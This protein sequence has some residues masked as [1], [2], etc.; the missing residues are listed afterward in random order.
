MGELGGEILTPGSD[1]TLGG[2]ALQ[3]PLPVAGMITSPQGY[4]TD[5]ITGETSYHMSACRLGT[6]KSGVPMNTIRIIPR[7]HPALPPGRYT[8]QPSR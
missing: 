8:P 4:R 1:T 7:H 2:G 6:A 3:W 5:P